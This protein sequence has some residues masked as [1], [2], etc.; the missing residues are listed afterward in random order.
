MVNTLTF[1]RLLTELCTQLPM[2]L[3]AVCI[4][5][6]ILITKYVVLYL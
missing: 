2:S 4:E 5:W 6:K 1:G 3:A